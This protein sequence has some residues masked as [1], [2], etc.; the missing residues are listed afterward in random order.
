MLTTVEKRAMIISYSLII[1]YL[2]LVFHNGENSFIRIHDYL[3]SW[4]AWFKQF[5]LN[6]VSYFDPKGLIR[7]LFNGAPAST[8]TPGFILGDYLYTLIPTIYAYIANE[9]VFRLVAFFGM[10]MLLK[11]HFGFLYQKL[12]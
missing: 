2:L 9:I 11:N 3:D 5:Y 6:R 4:P 10:V 8:V 12:K 1:A 7:S